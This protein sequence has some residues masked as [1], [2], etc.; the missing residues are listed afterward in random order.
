MQSKRD[1]VQAHS[2]VMSRLAAGMLL[3]DPDAP[4]TPLG[5][6]TRGAFAGVIVAVLVAA[7]ALVYGLIVPGGNDSWRSAGTLVVNK[8]TGARYLYAGGALRPVR[9]YASALLIAGS[10]LKV[11][12]LRGT[13]LRGT[14]IG[15]PLGVPGAPESV[16]PAGD[17]D[18]GPWQVC[19]TLTASGAAVTT[20]RVAR[21]A[22]G[23]PVG[24]RQGLLVRGPDRTTYLVWQGS[25]LRLD[26][27]SG[28][29]ISLGYGAVTPRPVSAAFLDTLVAGPDLA[30][31]RVPGLG[32][33][34]PALGSAPGRVG[35]VFRYSVSGSGAPT[36]YQLRR[37]G[38]VPVT[39]TDATLAL[40]DPA[41][42]A[43]Y[44]D[45]SPSAVAIGADQVRQHLAPGAA[46]RAPASTG[47]P[48][49]PPKAAAVP[50]GQAACAQALPG[51]DGTRVST[52][53]L[54]LAALGPVAVSGDVPASAACLP[55]D[56]VVVTPG[57]GALVRALGADGAPAG[58]T[59]YFVADNGE[60]YRLP[61]RAAVAALGF[62][63]A[64][65]T[66]LPS[67]LLAMLPSGPDLSP[68]SAAGAGAATT[69][70]A[71][72]AP[73]SGPSAAKR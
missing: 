19:S 24:V 8:D 52:V 56:G 49:T 46:G 3:A 73:V 17:L 60:K 41:T 2:F 62:S 26:E 55:V 48:A 32:T 11:R 33:A 51:P 70:P 14:P 31:P 34:G 65:A 71:C 43:A 36:Y 61:T 47:A 22:D 16:P 30:A 39:A 58:D 67:P 10:E 54:P 21:S 6:T 5:R 64:E 57:R 44:R 27:K 69:G 13:S 50:D 7:G 45:G 15:P 1:Q 42:R 12:D 72:A 9:N 40:G 68:Q 66:A 18:R 63:G 59:T 29:A 23:V 38:L 35:Q 28:A 25:R 53:L 4:E 20:L 37:E